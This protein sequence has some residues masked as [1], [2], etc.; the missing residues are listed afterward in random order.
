[1]TIQ[2]HTGLSRAD[3]QG[4]VYAVIPGD[5]ER[6]A[7]LAQAIDEQAKPLKSRREYDSYLADLAGEK[8]LVCST[9][10]GGPA[11]SIAMEELAELG[12]KSI[13]RVGTTGAIQPNIKVGDVIVTKAAVRLD[14]T[15]A[16]YAPIEYPAV[17]SFEFTGSAVKACQ[18]LAI[19]YHVGLTASSASFYAGQ[20][21]YDSFK[22]FVT[23]GFRGSLAE[24]CPRYARGLRWRSVP[25]AVCSMRNVCDTLCCGALCLLLV[26]GQWQWIRRQ[27]AHAARA[28]PGVMQ[29]GA[30][31]PPRHHDESFGVSAGRRCVAGGAHAQA[32]NGAR[33]CMPRKPVAAQPT[34]LLHSSTGV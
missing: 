29:C 22:G 8:I 2:Y 10:I 4:A 32:V 28:E 19:G 30:R 25:H 9:G 33:P 14:G 26:V 12:I 18:A 7:V 31:P 21:R 3:L 20:E 27:E 1:M 6:V 34:H 24:W 15:S 16:H 17:A 5:P 11:A 23:R 13:L